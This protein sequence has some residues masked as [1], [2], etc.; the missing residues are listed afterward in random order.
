MV[1]R[2][3]VTLVMPWTLSVAHVKKTLKAMM[4]SWSIWARFTSP[5]HSERDRGYT[6]T[7]VIKASPTRSGGRPY[8]EMV[9]SVTSIATTGAISS[10]TRLHSGNR[11]GLLASLPPASGRRCLHG[12]IMFS[13]CREF[14]VHMSHRHRATSTGVFRPK[15]SR[16][17]PGVSMARG[18]PWASTVSSDTRTWISPI[19]AHRTYNSYERT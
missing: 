12:G 8:V 16:R 17:L 10:T 3:T 15:V 19:G 5:K 4:T 1:N 7:Q 6:N 13:K 14:I 18:V 11:A 9:P 2:S